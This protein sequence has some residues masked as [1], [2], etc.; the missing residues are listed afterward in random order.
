MSTNVCDVGK[1]G[2]QRARAG[3]HLLC[4]AACSGLLLPQIAVERQRKWHSL[5]TRMK[6]NLGVL[7]TPVRHS[8]STELTVSLT[9]EP[10]VS[11]IGY[12]RGE[13][14]SIRSRD[15]R[16]SRYAHRRNLTSTSCILQNP[17]PTREMASVEVFVLT[18]RPVGIQRREA[19]QVKVLKSGG[20]LLS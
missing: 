20:A 10:G 19:H 18:P 3:G 15:S 16:C 8:S 7:D 12:A 13:G 14:L 1:P 9:R 6:G 4:C 17:P 5:G 2:T 11:L